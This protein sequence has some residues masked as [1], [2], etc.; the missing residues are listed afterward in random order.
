MKDGKD[1]GQSI[2][3]RE[4]GTLWSK[5]NHKNGKMDGVFQVFRRDGSKKFEGEYSKG[6]PDGYWKTWDKDGNPFADGIFKNGDPWEGTFASGDID[7][8][9]GPGECH[10]TTFKNGLQ[11]ATK[12]VVF[13]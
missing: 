5:S 12:V 10:I 13:E 3:Y 9:Y 8:E 6:K 2:N 1:H 11:T 7:G 4:D